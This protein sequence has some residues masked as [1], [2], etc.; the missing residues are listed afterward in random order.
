M[1]VTD[2]LPSIS[3]GDFVDAGGLMSYAPNY[4]VAFRR[5]T[6]YVH[7]ILKGANPAELPFEQPTQYEL[8]VM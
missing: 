6:E 1:P 8:V 4:A 7:R 2:C 5:A 3:L